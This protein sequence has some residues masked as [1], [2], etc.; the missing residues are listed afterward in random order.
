MTEL[1]QLEN[2]AYKNNVNI[3]IHPFKNEKIKGLYCDGTIALNTSLETDTEKK[4]ILAEELG[5]HY[6]A[7]GDILGNDIISIKQEAKGR[8]YAYN[9]LVGLSGLISA[10]KANCK[11]LYE[12]AEYLNVTEPFLLETIDTYKQKYGIFA[13]INNYIIYFEP[14]LTVLELK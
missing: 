13:H 5:H 8:I 3:V 9:K 14:R 11:S 6:T 2:E 4:C 7:Y 10:Y 12:I 1:E